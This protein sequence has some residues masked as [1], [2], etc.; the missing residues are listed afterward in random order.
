MNDREPGQTDPGD[1]PVVPAGGSGRPLLMRVLRLVF[2]V[3][4]VALGAH[5]IARDADGFL[6]ALTDI[7]PARTAI[8]LLL[9]LVG[10][11]TSAEV[12]RGAVAS[13]AARLDGRSA[14]RIFFV[15][16]LGKYI[17]GAVWTV[18]A[19]VEAARRHGLA[20]SRMAVGAV[21]FLAFYLLTGLLVV[22]ALLPLA[23]AGS[24]GAFLWP[25]LLI[26]LLVV[27]LLPPV[28]TRVIDLGLSLLRR[29]RLPRALNLKDV[30]V[31]SGW[32]LATWAIFG[33]AAVVVAQPLA[34]DAGLVELIAAAAGGFA[35]GWA[36]GLL[37]V[38]APAGLGPRD[39]VIFAALSPVVG[40]TEAA[41]VAIVLRVLHTIGDFG[42][43]GLAMRAARR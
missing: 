20:R 33:A 22:A 30:S 42:L 8:A 14:R 13:V 34:G 25:L 21:L 7:G 27:A 26:P 23:A 28:L 5:A 43:A 6:T 38:P 18:L 31:P 9:V 32:G 11:V 39:L 16:Q 17:P 37:V 12:W 1:A 4:A 29:D 36:V 41:S 15:S 35:L 40:A 3:A 24:L 19:Q 2:L 10:L